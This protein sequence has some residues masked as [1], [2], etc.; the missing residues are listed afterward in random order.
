MGSSFCQQ[1]PNSIYLGEDAIAV[2]N[3]A[4]K[5]FLGLPPLAASILPIVVRMFAI[6][7][8]IPCGWLGSTIVFWSA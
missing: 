7:S 8:Q 5:S 6:D 1:I 4:F 3:E 2:I